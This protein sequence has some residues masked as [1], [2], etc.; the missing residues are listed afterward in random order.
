[1]LGWRLQVFIDLARGSR[2]QRKDAEAENMLL[3]AERIA[4]RQSATR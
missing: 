4:P 2:Q 3:E 1:M